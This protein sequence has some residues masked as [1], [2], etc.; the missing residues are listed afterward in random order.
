MDSKEH[1]YFFSEKFR[2]LKRFYLIFKD[3]YI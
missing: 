2:T 1:K 3:P